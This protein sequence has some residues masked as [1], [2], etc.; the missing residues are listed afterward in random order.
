MFHDRLRGPLRL[1]PLLALLALLAPTVA[2]ADDPAPAAEPESVVI[3]WV[4]NFEAARATARKE[5]KD[6]LINFTGSDWCGWCKRLE[7]EVFAHKEFIDGIA[8][9]Y[10]M[11]FLDFPRAQEL[12]DK[13]V[14]AALNDRLNEEYEVA[15][16]PTILLTNA[17]GLPYGRTGYQPDGPAAYLTHL[18]ELRTEGAKVLEFAKLGSKATDAQ[19]KEVFPTLDE[20]GMLS[21]P[22][23]AWVKER[24]LKLDADGSLGFKKAI[25]GRAE[26]K[27]LKALLPKQRG[28]QPNW[29]A[30]YTLL[31]EA[32]YLSGGMYVNVAYGCANALLKDGRP[33]DARALAEKVA[34]DPIFED[35][36]AKSAIT[37]FLAQCDEAIKALSAA[38]E[39]EGEGEGESEDK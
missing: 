9:K 10:V 11:V 33:A 34:S 37:Q 12:K 14:D 22:G 18:T 8:A 16:Y 39:G 35:E 24:A 2:C 7:G 15:G 13:V 27:A 31:T 25:L 30:I 36:Q 28:E 1:L 6:L 26:Q 4:T 19:I 21:Y 29:T 5:G 20:G 3:P 32:K 23:F 17:E 38:K